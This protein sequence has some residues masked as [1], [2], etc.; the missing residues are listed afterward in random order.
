MWATPDLTVRLKF[1]P[2]NIGRIEIAA[3]LPCAAIIHALPQGV[4]RH[5][6]LGLHPTF[7]YKYS[8]QNAVTDKHTAL[9]SFSSGIQKSPAPNIQLKNGDMACVSLDLV[10]IGKQVTVPQQIWQ[11]MIKL[12]KLS[13]QAGWCGE[14]IKTHPALCKRGH[15]K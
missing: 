10:D 2:D 5:K 9:T 1:Q 15:C 13:Y 12:K 4:R 3:G 11:A 14:E 7:L 8:E 6:V